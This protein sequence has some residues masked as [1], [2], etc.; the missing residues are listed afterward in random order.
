MKKLKKE[1]KKE[2]GNDSYMWNKLNLWTSILHKYFLYFGV[3]FVS[4]R[5]GCYRIVATNATQETF[6]STLRFWLAERKA[7]TH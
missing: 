2:D 3:G 4:F 7:S 5:V 6:H 1:P